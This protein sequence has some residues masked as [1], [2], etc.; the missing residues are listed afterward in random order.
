MIHDKLAGAGRSI[1]TNVSRDGCCFRDACSYSLLTGY[2]AP[3][4]DRDV[5]ELLNCRSRGQTA[6]HL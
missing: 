6:I 4:I 3:L 2:E 5:R 1:L